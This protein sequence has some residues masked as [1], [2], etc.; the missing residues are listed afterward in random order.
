MKRKERVIMVHEFINTDC[1]GKEN[2]F[3]ELF[4]K[5]QEEFELETEF[6]PDIKTNRYLWNLRQTKIKQLETYL[7]YQNK[8]KETLDL[9]TDFVANFSQ[10]TTWALL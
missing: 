1:R 6:N 10:D 8:K 3:S 4:A 5:F 9:Y 2:K 7:N